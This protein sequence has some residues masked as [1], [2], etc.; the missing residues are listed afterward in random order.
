MHCSSHL[1]LLLESY[2]QL[3]GLPSLT[4]HDAKP[5]EVKISKDEVAENWHESN[6]FAPVWGNHCTDT[7]LCPS[8]AYFPSSMH[9]T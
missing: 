6:T 7:G 9:R 4:L 2:W 5:V 8:G 1:L 3:C